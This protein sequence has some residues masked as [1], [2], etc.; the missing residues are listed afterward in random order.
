MR[1]FEKLE[2]HICVFLLFLTRVLRKA[3]FGRVFS[4]YGHPSQ[5]ALICGASSVHPSRIFRYR[6]LFKLVLGV[7]SAL[8]S[9]VGLVAQALE[10]VVG[11]LFDHVQLEAL[12]IYRFYLFHGVD[13][14]HAGIG[15]LP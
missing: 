1:V 10:D 14:I 5:T 12:F 8:T 3:L 4:M 2:Q 11:I 13:G 6:G 15:L 9:R 7:Q